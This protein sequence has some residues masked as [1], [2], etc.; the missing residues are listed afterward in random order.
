MSI[1]LSRSAA[2]NAPLILFQAEARDGSEI[3]LQVGAFSMS[4]PEMER[5]LAELS[6]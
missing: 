2:H 4:N 5:V 1:G 6:Q 3:R